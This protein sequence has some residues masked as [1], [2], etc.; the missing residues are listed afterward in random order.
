MPP[1][2]SAPWDFKPSLPPLGFMDWG[3]KYAFVKLGAP[4][5]TFLVALD[6]GSDLFWAPCDCHQCATTKFDVMKSNCN[7][8]SSDSST[9]QKINL[10][11]QLMRQPKCM[12]CRNQ[13]LPL[14]L[15]NTFLL[16][17]P[18]FVVLVEDVLYLMTEDETPHIVEA[19]IVFGYVAFN[20]YNHL[21]PEW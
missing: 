3:F 15:S 12:H 1:T 19:P 14:L 2:C 17:L 20:C 5:V 16:I 10:Q 13:Q 11:Q 4:N 7:R 8:T 6:T 18:T 21:R 9:S